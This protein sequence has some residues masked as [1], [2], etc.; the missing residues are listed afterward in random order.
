MDCFP[1][2]CL[3]TVFCSGSSVAVA[4]K[5]CCL[6]RER[7]LVEAPSIPITGPGRV[8]EPVGHG[9]CLAVP[10]PHPRFRR[11][12][13]HPAVDRHQR[14]VELVCV[15]G[16]HLGGLGCGSCQATQAAH[17]LVGGAHPRQHRLRNSIAQGSIGRK[18]YAVYTYVLLVQLTFSRKAQFI[19]LDGAGRLLY[20]HPL[21]LPVALPSH[22]TS[23]LS[24]SLFLCS[25][26][27]TPGSIGRTLVR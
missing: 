15:G 18:Y 16:D 22:T 12:Q 8:L 19:Q 20:H 4:V 17:E 5:G 6:R 1:W 13:Q 10:H 7:F 27:T 26:L 24:P 3:R 25:S 9:H 11:H 21:P 14:R 2:S 23:T